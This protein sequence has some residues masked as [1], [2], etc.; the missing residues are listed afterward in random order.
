[1]SCH[2][3]YICALQVHAVEETVKNFTPESQAVLEERL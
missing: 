2:T 1:M 3:V